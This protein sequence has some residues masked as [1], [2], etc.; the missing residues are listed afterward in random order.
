MEEAMKHR[1]LLAVIV[2]LIAVTALAAAQQHAVA[3]QIHDHSSTDQRHDQ[4]LADVNKRGDQVMGFD[5]MKTTHHFRL[6]P[7]GGVI[8]VEANDPEDT[9][10]RDQIRRHLRHI[11]QLFAN[12]DFTAPMLIHAQTPPGAPVMKQMKAEIQYRFEEMER[13][14][15]VRIT[16][17]NRDAVAAVHEFLR[18]QIKDHATGD[19]GIVEKP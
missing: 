7:D 15:R 19:S 2:S 3:P 17:G 4:H 8:E 13:G 11:A 18:F 6:T 1:Y 5:H 14:G 16:T 10:S 9:A 12:G